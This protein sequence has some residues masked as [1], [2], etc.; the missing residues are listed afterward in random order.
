MSPES[1]LSIEAEILLMN[2]KIQR[3]LDHH[4]EFKDDI[5]AIRESIDSIKSSQHKEEVNRLAENSEIRNELHG[6]I[7]QILYSILGG[8]FL[9]LSGI[10]LWIVTG[11]HD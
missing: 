9:F 3:I 1:K 8:A 10:A 11:K 5:F 6:R 4:I 2:Q 7:N